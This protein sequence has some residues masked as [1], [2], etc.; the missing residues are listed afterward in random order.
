[1]RR[2]R[3]RASDPLGSFRLPDGTAA[4][5][6]DLQ[7]VRTGAGAGLRWL[8]P[9]GPLRFD[10]AWKLDRQPYEDSAPVFSL[11]YGNPF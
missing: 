3:R 6:F 2:T 9:I 8:S 7:D 11:S 10:V 4:P 1:M 5:D